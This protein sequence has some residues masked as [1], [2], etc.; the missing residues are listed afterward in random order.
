MSRFRSKGELFNART[1]TTDYN[2]DGSSVVTPRE[3]LSKATGSLET[4]T[5]VQIPH[6]KKLRAEGQVFMN[7]VTQTSDS[8]FSIESSLTLG[9]V[10]GWGTRVITGDVACAVSVPY[11]FQSTNERKQN[12]REMSVV[13]AHAK[14]ASSV[15]MGLVSV[16]EMH[17]T[18][19]MLRS[20]FKSARSLLDKMDNY[21]LNDIQKGKT[22]A[23]AAANAWL[24]YR[25]GWK[26]LMFEIQQTVAAYK[27]LTGSK[28]VRLVARGSQQ[29]EDRNVN[30]VA[31]TFPGTH[32]I[33]VTRDLTRTFKASTGV[34]YE[35]SETADEERARRFGYRLSDVPSSGWEL[36]TGSW[37]VDRFLAVGYW[38]DAITPKPGVKILG[39]WLTEIQTD[40]N[41]HILTDAWVD[42]VMNNV[43]YPCHAAGGSYT[44]VIRS[45]IRTA[46]PSL[47]SLPPVNPGSQSLAQIIDDAA[48]I[49][50][51]LKVFDVKLPSTS[52]KRQIIPRRL[53]TI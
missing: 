9:P 36:I 14:I 22:Y 47:P 33:R 40:V 43:T 16:A 31:S 48:F 7:P 11:V 41:T 21:R 26:P 45:K 1:I 8:R 44:E 12:C 13:K 52:R 3:F 6:F 46:N 38:L 32:G 17:K 5:D 18:V 50:N 29:I 15:A 49:A 23:K 20:P 39:S 2:P 34:L 24:E 37:M 35:F 51:R 42:V 25:L 28:S 10:P 30:T 19:S 27:G 4:I 53:R